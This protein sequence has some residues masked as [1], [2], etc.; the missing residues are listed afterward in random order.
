MVAGNSPP[1]VDHQKVVKIVS[2]LVDRKGQHSKGFEFLK[3]EESVVDPKKGASSPVVTSPTQQMRDLKHG[4]PSLVM[5]PRTRK[6]L[7]LFT[8]KG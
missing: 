8:A 1:F 2:T 7:D 6:A 4:V 3:R 5:A